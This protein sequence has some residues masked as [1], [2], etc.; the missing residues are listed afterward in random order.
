MSLSAL[1]YILVPSRA[2]KSVL[3]EYYTERDIVEESFFLNHASIQEVWCWIKMRNVECIVIPGIKS[4]DCGC[5]RSYWSF[6]LYAFYSSDENG[7][8]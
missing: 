7:G 2:V 8:V 6:L 1:R 4:Y 5:W 3:R